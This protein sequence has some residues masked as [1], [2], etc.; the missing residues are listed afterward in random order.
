MHIEGTRGF[1]LTWHARGTPG[2]IFMRKEKVPFLYVP[3]CLKNPC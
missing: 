2:G 3:T 1:G